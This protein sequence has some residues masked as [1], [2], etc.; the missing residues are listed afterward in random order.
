MVAKLVL[1]L[2][3]IA[4]V[5][6]FAMWLTY[7]HYEQRAERRHERQLARE[8]RDWELLERELEDD[9]R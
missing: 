7:R 8:E 2:V 1:A 6:G 4:A 9:E 5:I 3:A